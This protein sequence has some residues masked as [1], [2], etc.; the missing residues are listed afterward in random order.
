M[1]KISINRY[2]PF[3]F[4][5]LKLGENS[6]YTKHISYNCGRLTGILIVGLQELCK[7]FM[8][9]ASDISSLYKV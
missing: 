8:N 9:M 6:Q 5:G 3:N 1:W 4:R 7:F 2:I